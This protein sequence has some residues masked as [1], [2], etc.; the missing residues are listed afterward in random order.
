MGPLDPM[1]PRSAAQARGFSMYEERET[2]EAKEARMR[3]WHRAYQ[4]SR[5]TFQ[6]CG[7]TGMGRDAGFR[8]C[9]PSEQ[10]AGHVQ[11]PPTRPR[12]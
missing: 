6:P 1:D 8:P 2:D 11:D 3:E 7:C 9:T 10:R 5:K 4:E 12:R